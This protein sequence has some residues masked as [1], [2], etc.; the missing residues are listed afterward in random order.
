MSGILV[1]DIWGDYAHFKKIETTTSP[2][3]YSVPTG[4]V[5]AGLVAGIMGYERDTYYEDFS[6]KNIEYSL[7]VL[8]PISKIRINQ[9]LINTAEKPFFA[10]Y[11]KNNPRTQIP[12]EY[13][14]DPN[15][16]IYLFIKKER[17]RKELKQFLEKHRSVFTPYLGLSEHLANFEFIGEFHGVRKRASETKIHSVVSKDKVKIKLA[18]VE[19]G[20]RW[21][22]ER[23]PLYMD[24][25]RVVREYANILF[26]TNGRPIPIENVE[27]FQIGA[28]NVI[29][30]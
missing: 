6:R 2:L 28:D 4:T 5:L 22:L 21:V 7:K 29:F 27:Y 30:L 26:D 15:Y 14:R 11:G 1:F 10:L 12:Y 13:L 18:D 20:M 17:I 23:I 8:E 25:E 16:R 3:T 24:Q 9:N 19:E